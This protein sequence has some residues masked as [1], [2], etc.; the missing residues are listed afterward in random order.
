MVAV[1]PAFLDLLGL[2]PGSALG[3]TVD[4]GKL[5]LEPQ[6][7]PSYSLQDLLAQCDPSAPLDEDPWLSDAAAGV[8]LL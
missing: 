4:D 6:A 7:R 3:V 8:E 2:R 5:I 1:P